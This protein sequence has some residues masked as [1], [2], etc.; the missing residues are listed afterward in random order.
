VHG[1]GEHCGRYEEMAAW[2][3][4]R[5]CA[6]HAYDQQGH[7]LSPGRRG[8]VQ[9]FDDLLDDLGAFI[10]FV[11]VHHR[12]IPRV[13]VGHS[14]GGLVVSA[15]ACER[16]PEIDLLITSG[17]ALALPPDLSTTKR[18]LSRLLQRL[19]PRLTMDA[20]LDAQG[21][22]RDPDVVRRYLDD[23]LVHARVTAGL[24]GAML[25]AVQRT[26]ASS[27]RVRVPMLLLHGEDDSLCLPAGSIAFH[28]GLPRQ[29][30]AGSEIR[31]YPNLKHEIFNE[32]ER[33]SVFADLLGWIERRESD[34]GSGDE[35]QAGDRAAGNGRYDER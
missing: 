13:L 8:H 23:P 21:L 34:R 17:A 32:P 29:D 3:A 11:A 22:S 14:M 12:G 19:L 15:M 25:G 35:T 26:A 1:F 31:T 33:E 30:V 5:G 16:K 9:R 20:G 24:G 6:V 18:M 27:A 7:G 2:L 4:R 28:S 10:E